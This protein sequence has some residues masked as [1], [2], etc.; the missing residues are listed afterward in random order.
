MPLFGYAIFT[1]EPVKAVHII[2]QG[3]LFIK[4]M[5]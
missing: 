1:G 3:F 4:H 5:I 2:R